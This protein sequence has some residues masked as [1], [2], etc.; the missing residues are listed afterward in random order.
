[1]SQENRDTDTTR[2]GFQLDT[3]PAEA[4]V[5]H[6]ADPRFQVAFRKFA[7]ESLGLKNYLPIV[8]GGGVHAL[9]AEEYAPR[10]FETLWHQV[11]FMLNLFK[12]PEV[13]LIGHEDCRW[14]QNHAE[15]FDGVDPATRCRLDLPKVAEML[16]QKLPHLTIRCYW[17]GIEGD[18]VT[19]TPADKH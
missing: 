16:K 13:I 15:H 12:L 7:T 17:A 18:K 5:I 2:G 14:Y 6:C 11:T 8:E 19:F 3:A 4:M 1:M 9:R 10:E